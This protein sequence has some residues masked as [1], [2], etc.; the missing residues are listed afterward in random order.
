MIRRAFLQGVAALTGLGQDT[1]SRFPYPGRPQ[2]GQGVSPSQGQTIRARFVI[3]TSVAGGLFAYVGTPGPGNAPILWATLGTTDPYG[4][5]LPFSGVGVKNGS[6]LAGINDQS[7]IVVGST[8][9]A[10]LGTLNDSGAGGTSL[11]S[12]TFGVGD[13][14]AGLELLSKNVNGIGPRAII[15][16]AAL[17]STGG[18]AANPSDIITDTWHPLTLINGWASVTSPSYTLFPDRTVMVAGV[19][20]SAGAAGNPIFANLPA[21]P[22][23]YRPATQQ[24]TAAGLHGAPP[25]GG[26]FMRAATNGDLSILGSTAVTGPWSVNWRFSLDYT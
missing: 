8:G 20:S 1:P 24:E 26:A 12:S 10:T 6:D 5:A 23:S 13:I 7:S 22:P 18:T 3:I 9:E 14:L 4:N 2:P 19:I 11:A 15:N 25:A 17:I 16:N 21:G